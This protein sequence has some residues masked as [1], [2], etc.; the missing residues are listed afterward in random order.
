[1]RLLRWLLMTLGILAVVIAGTA[2]ILYARSEARLRRV[3]QAVVVPPSV[4][5]RDAQAI[6]RGAHVAT[7]MGS[8]TLC[9]GQDL[10]G[11]V[12][13]DAGPMF[14]ISAPNLTRGRGG[15]G[16]RFTT[17]D[18]VRA[19]R[20]GIRAD[21]TSLLVM[22]S[23]AFVHMNEP[24][25]AALIAYLEQVPPVDREAAPTHL[26]A[27]GRALL[28]LGRLEILVA[29]KT[30]AIPY[31]AV[32]PPG[33]T[34]EYGA[35]LAS[36]TGCQGCH[37]F[38]LSGGRVFGPPGVP[39]ASNLTPDPATGIASW[40]EADFFKA[41]RQGVRP[42]G[43][44]IDPF[45]PWPYLGGMTDDELRAIWRYLRSVPPRPFGLR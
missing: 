30:P 5:A 33:A 6:R 12:F 21:G 14:F 16:G 44:A 42:D 38:G 7:T 18:W 10:G 26:R 40:T 13:A 36:F 37:G 27:G 19:I 25:L 1:M 28:A 39:P 2:G 34:A 9:H 23:E 22:P 29:D 41:M 43:R 17:I 24:D 45:M 8:C 32:V 4:I 15:L 20:H 31:P 11:Q 35:Y 3:H